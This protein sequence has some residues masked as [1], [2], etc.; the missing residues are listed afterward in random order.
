MSTLRIHS[1]VVVAVMLLFT[2][3]LHPGVTSTS[4]RL[5]E[6]E[7]IRIAKETAVSKGIDLHGFYEPEARYQIADKNWFV[8]FNGRALIPGNFFTVD[9]DDQTKKTQY[10]GGE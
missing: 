4:A 7:V 9:V 8:S 10:V 6:V 3:C 1:F 5:S 2:G